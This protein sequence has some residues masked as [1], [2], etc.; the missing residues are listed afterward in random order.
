MV[1][2]VSALVG[3]ILVILTIWFASPY[4]ALREI[5][6]GVANNNADAVSEHVDYETLRANM[7]VRV[8]GYMAEA[9]APG[10]PQLLKDR[11]VSQSRVFIDKGVDTYVTPEMLKLLTEVKPVKNSQGSD[12]QDITRT[13]DVRWWT[14]RKSLN[15]LWLHV[16]S[17]NPKHDG[18]EVVVHLRRVSGVTWK[19]VDVDPANWKDWAIQ[20]LRMAPPALR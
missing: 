15:E 7:K 19:V 17:T 11:A 6:Q 18:R 12:I 20:R 3:T 16:A 13:W 14:E 2:W 8:A 1:K 10:M 9:L 4:S 5:Q